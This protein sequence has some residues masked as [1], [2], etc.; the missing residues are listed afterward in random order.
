MKRLVAATLGALAL[1]TPGI[2]LASGGWTFSVEGF[3]IIDFVIFAGLLVYF[4]RGP[5]KKFLAARYERITAE[6]TAAS[7]LKAEADLKLLEVEKLLSDFEAEVGRIREQFRQDGEREKARVLADASAQTEKLR[8]TV[9][10]QLEQEAAALKETLS[11]ELTAAV[12]ASTEAKVKAK[13]DQATHK[14]LNGSYIDSLEKLE[15]LA[16]L[17]KAA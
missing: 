14:A 4:V 10:K 3:Y 7:R 13:V 17:V 11:K 16:T 12:L 15:S 2:A 6:I 1:L 9:V 5:A 8:T